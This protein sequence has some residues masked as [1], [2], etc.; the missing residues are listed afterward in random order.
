MASSW[1][2]LSAQLHAAVDA[3]GDFPLSCISGEEARTVLAD[4]QTVRAKLDCVVVTALAAPGPAELVAGETGHRSV[5]ALV[6]AD[7][8]QDPRRIGSDMRLGLWLTDYPVLAE[9]FAAGTICAAQVRAIRAR[10]NVRTRP[11]LDDAQVALVEAAQTCQW[12]EFLAVLRYWEL[13]ADPDGA[14]PEE[15]V[16]A[17]SMNYTKR[18]DGTVTGRF[19]L[20]P[21]GGH[22]FVSALERRVQALFRDDAE[23]GSLRTAGQRRADALVELVST[24]DGHG[25]TSSASPLVHVVMSEQLVADHFA[26]LASA[27]GL[28]IERDGGEHDVDA[29]DRLRIDPLDADGRCELIDGSPIHPHFALATLAGATFRRMVLSAESERMDLGRAVRGFPP[30]LKHALLVRARGRCQ[31]PGCDAPVQW[32]QADHLIPWSRCGETSIANGQIL[33]DP[34]NKLKRDRPQRE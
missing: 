23:S 19:Q 15:Q 25:R 4:L 7:T 24:G 31:H 27:G 20:D 10:E 30:Q 34:H 26:R 6:A 2:Q 1:N 11:F 29:P 17:R 18:A 32:M 9:A 12:S 3:A 16:A 22:A 5:A 8:R 33:C 28:T 14:E 21:L 13:A